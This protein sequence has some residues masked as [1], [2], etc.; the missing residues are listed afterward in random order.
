MRSVAKTCFS[1]PLQRGASANWQQRLRLLAGRAE[2][3]NQVP[4]PR[5]NQTKPN[6]RSD[7]N[8]C[9]MCWCGAF[10]SKSPFAL[11]G[12]RTVGSTKE[13]GYCTVHAERPTV[14]PELNKCNMRSTKATE[15]ANRRWAFRQA[16][17][18]FY[19]VKCT[20]FIVDWTFS[21]IIS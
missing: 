14:P 21:C 1:A 4:F 5:R 18:P 20:I 13:K 16:F 3:R 7:W 19:S 8:K 15:K 9:P 6:W 11:V 10:Y 17:R 12:F 2:A